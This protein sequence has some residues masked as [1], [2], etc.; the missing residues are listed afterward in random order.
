MDEDWDDEDYDEGWSDD[1]SVDLIECSSCG[2]EIYEEAVQCPTCGEYVT[3]GVRT[4][5]A[6]EGRPFWWVVVGLI[7]IVAAMLA[8][9][10]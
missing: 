2:S 10:R 1:D 9:V 4:G 8:L 6:W 7:G 5:T 3:R